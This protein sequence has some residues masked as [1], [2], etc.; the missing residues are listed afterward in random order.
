MTVFKYWCEVRVLRKAEESMVNTFQGHSLR[1]TLHV[2]LTN[3]ILNN[4]LYGKMWFN[5]TLR[6]YTERK[7]KM[8]WPSL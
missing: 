8:A 1:I 5:P 6:G 7:I 3:P 2:P 4:K